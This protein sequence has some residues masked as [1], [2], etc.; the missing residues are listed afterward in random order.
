MSDE[1][2]D[3]ADEE[4]E[5]QSSLGDVTPDGV[6]VSPIEADGYV[7]PTEVHAELYEILSHHRGR[8]NPISSE[9]LSDRVGIDDGVAWPTTRRCL[10]DLLVVGVPLGSCDE[11]YFVIETKAESE[12]YK[13][14]LEGRIESTRERIELVDKAVANAD[15]I[16]TADDGADDS[17]GDV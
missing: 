2:D 5:L 7:F 9:K 11:G 16:E 17:G 3:G 14:T 4:F 6:D 1:R 13:A 8:R 15:H 10:R 12:S